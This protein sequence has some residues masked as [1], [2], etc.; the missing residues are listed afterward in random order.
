MTE[1]TVPP[2]SAWVKNPVPLV[3]GDDGLPEPGKGI[4]CF[5]PHCEDIQMCSHMGDA[6]QGRLEIVDYVRVPEDLEPGNYVLGWYACT[7]SHSLQPHSLQCLQTVVSY[8]LLFGVSFIVRPAGEYS[9]DVCDGTLH[10]LQSFIR[11]WDCTQT[12]LGTRALI[13]FS[14]TSLPHMFVLLRDPE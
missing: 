3:S 6:T 2:G 14:E 4:P 11:R 12:P 7:L 8:P 9:D 10:C 13:W 1:G 5:P